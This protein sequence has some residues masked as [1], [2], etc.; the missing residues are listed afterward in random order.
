MNPLDSFTVE[1][2]EALSEGQKGFGLAMASYEES[3][4]LAKIALA[5]KLAKPVAEVYQPA[6]NGIC[7]PLGVN[8]RMFAALE[9]GTKLY[10]TPPTLQ[11]PDGWIAVPERLTDDWLFSIIPAMARSMP[12]SH[13]EYDYNGRNRRFVDWLWGRLIYMAPKLPPAPKPE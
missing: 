5:V 10:A 8:I 1:R 6:N 9:D 3:M 4:L 12:L 13:D 7:A 11:L 2:L